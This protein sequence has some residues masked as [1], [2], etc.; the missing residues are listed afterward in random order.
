MIDRVR[1][2]ASPTLRNRVVCG[3]DDRRRL[4][5]SDAQ[6]IITNAVLRGDMADGSKVGGHGDLGAEVTVDG[7]GQDKVGKATGLASNNDEFCRRSWVDC[8]RSVVRGD[9][10]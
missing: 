3:I 4:G 2:N 6:I 1:Q 9:L 5:N 10:F 8:L 7:R